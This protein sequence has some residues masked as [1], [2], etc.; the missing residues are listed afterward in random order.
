MSVRPIRGSRGLL[1]VALLVLAVGCGEPPTAHEEEGE[2]HGV[3]ISHAG[4]PIVTIDDG[5]VTGSLAVDV[6]DETPDYDIAFLDHHGEPITGD[7]EADAT[8]EDPALALF[9]STGAFQAH[10]MGLS[11]GSTTVIVSLVHA[12]DRDAHY[13]SPAIGLDVS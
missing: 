3:I 12:A 11:A 13:D 2:V 7:F 10:F 5:V 9:H 1:S 6:G 4:M 8:I